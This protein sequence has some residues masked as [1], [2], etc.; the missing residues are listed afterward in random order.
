MQ[1]YSFTNQAVFCTLNVSNLLTNTAPQNSGLLVVDVRDIASQYLGAP[2]NACGAG[3]D[4]CAVSGGRGVIGGATFDHGQSDSSEDRGRLSVYS[5]TIAT[6]GVISS[7]PN[8]QFTTDTA[9]QIKAN[10]NNRGKIMRASDTR[11]A[12]LCSGILGAF[13]YS[14]G[15]TITA[16]GTQPW[17]MN[18]G[19]ASYPQN[20]SG[21]GAAHPQDAIYDAATGKV[22]VYYPDTANFRRIMRT[23]FNVNTGLLTLEETQVATNTG[24]SGSTNVHLRTPRGPVDER[25]VQVHLGNRA[26]DLSLSTVHVDETSLNQA[27]NAPALNPVS[28]FSASSAK[29][30]TWVYSDNN[31]RDA[32]TAYQLQIRD[33]S[34]GT[35]VYDSGKVTTTASSKV[36]AASTLSNNEIYEWRVRTYDANDVVSA[37]SAYQ[38]FS[39]TNTGIAEITVPAVD[40]A[41]GLASPTLEI[42]WTFTASGSV[43]QARY[44]VSVLRTDTGAQLFDSQYIYGPDVR[45]FTITGLVTDVEQQIELRIEDSNGELSNTAVRLVTPVFS[46]PNGPSIMAQASADG[47][48]IEVAVINPTATGDLPPAER[49]DIYRSEADA[50]EFIK[51][52]EIFPSGIFT[53]YGVASDTLYDYKVKAVAQ[54]KTESNTVEDVSTVFEGVYVHDPLDPPGTVRQFLYGKSLKSDEVSTSST[55]QH[56]V[57]RSY[58]VYQFGTGLDQKVSVTVQV[59]AGSTAKTELAY[60]RNIANSKRVH[61]YRDSRGRR[62]FGVVVSVSVTDEDWGNTVSMDVTRADFDESFPE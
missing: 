8:K 5:Y 28:T 56:F 33:Q 25:F 43:T 29:T 54:G 23:G 46:G 19:I 2:I 12:V 6:N 52:G 41:P 34:S 60:L 32:Q 10:G 27:P 7:A 11:F 38:Q 51:V 44:R 40:N 15:G 61:C 36:L 39:T 4:V 50:N 48:G 30:F 24:A 62:V 31:P 35:V 21:A 59:P 1:G 14:T 58:P 45:A 55:E 53:D 20:T 9:G 57:G 22:W 47:S 37:Y 3:L 26:A 42:N 16:T 17:L 49:N 13:T 18:S